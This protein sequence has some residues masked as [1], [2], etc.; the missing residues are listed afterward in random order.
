MV[1][2]NAYYFFKPII[3]WHVRMSLRRLRASYKREAFANVWPIDE[4]AGSLPPGWPGWPGGKR[5]A[6]VLTHDVEGPRGEARVERLAELEAK[7][8][9]RSSFNFVPEGEYQVNDRLRDSLEQSG[10][11][12]GVHGLEHDGKLYRSKTKFAAKAARIR[13]YARNWNASGFRSPLMQHRLAWLHELGTEYDGST[14]DTDPFEPEPDG[15]RT[16]FPFW[17]PGPDGSGYVELP[18]TLVQDFTLFAVLREQ[19][20][21]IW[22][23]KLDWIVERGGMALINTHP[24]YMHFGGCKKGRDEC[25]VSYYEEFLRYAREKYEG[26]YWAATPR[27]VS[28]YYRNSVPV[29][30][31][32]TRKKICMLAYTAYEYDNRVRR[33]AETLAKRG[34]QVDVIAL[35]GSQF[36]KPVETLRGVTVYRIQ[37]RDCNERH[38]FSYAWRL[39][40]FLL[41][42]S[43]VLA[44]LHK[45]NRYDLVHVH[46]MPDFLA[47]AAWSPK[48]GGTRVILDVHDLT[49]EL[50]ASKFGTT[51]KSRYVKFLKWIERASAS[52]VD[53]V[54]VSNDL[55]RE[56]LIA[57]SV[58]RD[59]C[60]VFLNHADPAIFHHRPRT[61]SD[62]KFVVLFHGSFQWHQGLELAIE[63]F[64]HLRQKLPNAELHLY[65]GGGN[66]G[67]VELKRLSERLGLSDCVKFCGSVS[68]D[69]IAD[70]IANA[71]LGVVP[72][73][74]DSFGNEA[75]STK[76]MEFMSQG[77]PVVVS[78][79]KVDTYYFD[80]KTV[81]FFPSGDSRALADA[82]LEVAT[83]E[84]LRRTL[85][86]RGYEYVERNGWG[87]KKQE[88]I[89][90]VDS[91]STERFD[92]SNAQH[93]MFFAQPVANRNFPIE[94]APRARNDLRADASNDSGLALSAPN[95][96]SNRAS[97][98]KH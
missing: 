50:F 70:V 13:E 52:F 84:D 58:S 37:Y 27:E 71:D 29:T 69:H 60:S 40:R 5:F 4:R 85:I 65:G 6:F 93:S 18:Y 82:I 32:N 1:V 86:A 91:L 75:Y 44:R 49:P 76:I 42:S 38:K 73:R 9:F 96:N 19:S 21:D 78:Q 80:A 98:S 97:L 67:E 63:A 35:S 33:Y 66:N 88:Y 10:Y 72:K 64:A 51:T 90:L 11:E 68:L 30:S 24:D 22:K 55:W 41:H 43:I 23:R 34:D 12:V 62:E 25:P 15:V 28:R 39:L 14:F 79:T 74:A 56:T 83:N 89:D 36:R 2:N 77:V 7:Y 45:Q 20:I 94:L 16:I 59:K 17:V 47:F 57:R 8:G 92:T 31:R 54:I 53:H 3:P 26:S 61:R 48:L 81:H 46:N 87:R 95:T